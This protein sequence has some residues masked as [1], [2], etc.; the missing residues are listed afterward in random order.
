M[1]Q[2]EFGASL[3]RVFF[4]TTRGTSWDYW[5]HWFAKALN[6]HSEIDIF[7]GEGKRPKYFAERTRAERPDI[8]LFANFLAD[9]NLGYQAI[10]DCYS[11]RPYQMIPLWE[12]YGRTIPAINLVRHPYAWLHFYVTWRTS[13]LGMAKGSDAVLEHEWKITRHDLFK[14]LGLEYRKEEVY[15]WAAF[16]GMY[17]L[18][19]VPQDVASGI[20]LVRMEALVK[21]Q[22]IFTDVVDYLSRGRLKPNQDFLDMVY[23]WRYTPPDFMEKK[24]V[25]PSEEYA[26]WPEWKK[27][28]FRLLHSDEARRCFESYGYKY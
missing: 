19:Y 14:Q 4:V 6:A 18:N 12:R 5:Y 20:R 3:N 21:N 15:K 7:F 2:S 16:Q 1:G 9:A 26:A 23:A 17:H 8:T 25:I 28:A 22:T 10:G 27:E 11:Y 24:R 13:N